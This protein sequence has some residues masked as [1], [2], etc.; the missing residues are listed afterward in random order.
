LHP[1]NHSALVACE[2]NSVLVRVDLGTATVVATSAV[3]NTPDVLSV[4]PG[5]DW[6][7]VAAESGELTVFDLSQ[8]GLV[9]IDDETIDPSAHTVAVDP[10]THRFFFPCRRHKRDTRTSHHAARLLK[11]GSTWRNTE[12]IA[13]PLLVDLEVT[14]AMLA[15]AA[16][17]HDGK[18]GES[19]RK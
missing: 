14:S 15:V 4:D 10:A 5:K 3:G 17:S 12:E 19:S 13:P 2:I 11:I 6:L 16:D 7:F 9:K 18:L 1:D 8:A